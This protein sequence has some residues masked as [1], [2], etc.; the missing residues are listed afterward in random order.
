MWSNHLRLVNLDSLT[1]TSADVARNAMES[2]LASSRAYGVIPVCPALLR[3]A[4]SIGPG[5][6][7]LF[8]RMEGVRV[9]AA[10]L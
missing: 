10:V 8:D 9:Y 2:R 7:E 4:F 6:Q 3:F 1:G 5:S